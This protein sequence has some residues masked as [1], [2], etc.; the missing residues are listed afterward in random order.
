[1]NQRLL[2]LHGALGT[3]DQFRSLRKKLSPDFEIHDLDFEG[4]GQRNSAK[5]YTMNLFA[6][7]VIEYLHENK[8]DKTHIFGYSM[9]GYVGLHVAKEHPAFVEKIITLGT[10]FA[11]SNEA[12][13]REIK[14]LDLK[15]IEEKVPA[16]AQKL[17]SIHTN[18]NWKE[19]VIRTA[20]MM[21]EMG[22]GERLTKENLASIKQDVLIGVGDKDSMVSIE[23]SRETANILPNGRLEIIAGFRH[24][25][26][27]V[28]Q[29][30]L[31]CLIV[32]FLKDKPTA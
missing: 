2:L 20:N 19:V 29:E 30:E 21:Y 32:N 11:W 18:N 6:E 4:H 10:K 25:I 16:F 27:E 3:K 5:S 17:A 26:D 24:P 13:E 23:E 12:A 9:G 22:M 8:I 7:N 1:M 15:K 31:G 14:M 28:D